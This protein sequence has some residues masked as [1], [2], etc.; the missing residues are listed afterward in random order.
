MHRDFERILQELRSRGFSIERDGDRVLVTLADS[1]SVFVLLRADDWVQ[2]ASCIVGDD[3]IDASADTHAL[4]EF[5]LHVHGRYL[6]CRFG[7]DED[8]SLVMMSDVYPECLDAGHLA[9][10]M[11]QMDYVAGALLPVI[12]AACV[13]GELPSDS[14]VDR[15]FERS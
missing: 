12:R 14:E 13:S 9:N 6:G 4:N 1:A 7:Y 5:L 8:G 2:V 11:T 3:E 10:V 15:A